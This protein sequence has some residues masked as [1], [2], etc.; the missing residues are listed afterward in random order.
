V[1]FQFQCPLQHLILSKAK[2]SHLDLADN[3]VVTHKPIVS[4]KLTPEEEDFWNI[5]ATSARTFKF[6][7]D[8]LLMDERVDFGDISTTSLLASPSTSKTVPNIFTTSPTLN[9]SP[10][11]R[12]PP[13]L[14]IDTPK[15]SHYNTSDSPPS[16]TRD[17]VNHDIPKPVVKTDMPAMFS[18]GSSSDGISGIT[19][20]HK[21][22]LIAV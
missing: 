9:L 6:T 20:T 10:E 5:P 7:G 4:P 1:S 2:K 18:E 8:S 11:R 22:E 17:F 16:Q 19:I 21:I 14:D 15:Q 13:V 3:K 12:L